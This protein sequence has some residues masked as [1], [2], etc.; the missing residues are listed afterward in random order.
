MDQIVKFGKGA[1]N[2]GARMGW[3]ASLLALAGVAAVVVAC[4]GTSDEPTSAPAN[5]QATDSQPV[6]AA[7]DP[8]ATAKPAPTPTVEPTPTLPAE[9][10]E[11]T[12]AEAT[13]ESD[14]EDI[15]SDDAEKSRAATLRTIW[16]WKT[17]LEERTIPLTEMKIVL[18]RDK[19][20]P[21]DFPSFVSVASAPDYMEPREPVV[22][23][24]IGG[25]ARAYPLAI[26]MWHEIVNDTVGGEPV[27]VTFCP[28]CNTGITF[29]RIVDGQELTFGTSGMLRNSDLVM[30]DRQSES[31]W[32]QITGEALAGDFAAGK[33]VLT[34]LPSSIIAWETFAETYPKGQLLERV[35]NEYGSPARPYDSPPYAG[36]DNVDDQPF[37]YSGRLDDRLVATSRVLTIDGETPVAYPF[38]FLEETPVVND[39]V[40]S[41]DI[42]AF[43][44]NGT[45]SAFKSLSNEHRV[46]GSVAVFSRTVGE[47]SLTFEATDGGIIDAETGSAWNY[48]GVAVDGELTGTQ[49][50]PVIHANHFWFAWAVFKP[51]TE[52]RDSID[53]L[54]G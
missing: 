25:E 15:F 38:S 41:E 27:T 33:T 46:S 22:A 43:F 18:G 6:A 3:T 13:Q 26:L 30:W 36:Y 48:A 53:E 50:E 34:Q 5:G 29:S 52:I 23:L 16:G 44:D 28:L 8:T 47:R 49:L 32:Q 42:V 45:F 11:K 20:A 51:A 9:E 10:E 24:I 4:G 7:P 14:F 17:N 21:I 12:A 31:F 39:S 1:K 40:N 54:A 35:I 19:I 2:A 37:L